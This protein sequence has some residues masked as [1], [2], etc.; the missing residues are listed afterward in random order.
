M[1]QEQPVGT[2][3][4]D[5][6]SDAGLRQSVEDRG[7]LDVLVFDV[8][9]SRHSQLFDVV[10]P[11]GQVRVARTVDRDAI[12]YKRS[13]CVIPLDVAIVR[14]SPEFRVCSLSDHFDLVLCA[15]RNVELLQ[16]YT[17]MSALSLIHI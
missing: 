3:V 6:V 2:V 11:S 12:C 9:Q 7:V 1:L 17:A 10:S 14:P 8:F 15:D 13:D 16:L 4:A 5:L